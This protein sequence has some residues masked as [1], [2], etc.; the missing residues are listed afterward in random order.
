VPEF[1]F[2]AR[3]EVKATGQSSPERGYAS[4]V[5]FA[6]Y[7]HPDEARSEAA[8]EPVPGLAFDGDA[9]GVRHSRFGRLVVVNSGRGGS[10]F[11]VC[12][13]CGYAEPGV[14]GNGTP[15]HENP[16][17]GAGCGGTLYRYD[18]GHSFLTDVTEFEV[19]H[20]QV[21]ASPSLLYALLEGAALALGIRRADIDGTIRRSPTRDSLFLFDNVPGGAGHARRIA[22][23]AHA[24]FE[25]ALRSVSRDCCGPETSCYECLRTYRNQFYHPELARGAARESLERLLGRIPLAADV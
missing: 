10:G 8:F 5:Y 12:P 3:R 20:P 1:G 25:G 16:R 21:D 13:S 7:D 19:R 17:T 4:R 14:H 9:A 24:V 6:R 23:D 15:G 2:I 11:R 22:E 18:L